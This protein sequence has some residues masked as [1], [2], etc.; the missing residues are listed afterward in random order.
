M[1]LPVHRQAPNRCMPFMKILLTIVLT[2]CFTYTF[3]QNSEDNKYYLPTDVFKSEIYK[4]ERHPKFDGEIKKVGKT[5]YIFGE[6]KLQIS[7]EDTTMWAIFRTG[8]FNPDIVFGKETTYKEQA[9]LDT[10]S[11]NQRILYNLV[12]NDSL[13]ICCFRGTIKIPT[14]SF[15]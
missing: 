8:I 14:E 2:V 5:Y 4:A 1:L 6:K 13:S 12:R 10:M 3:G 7:L 9:E 11:Q 15:G